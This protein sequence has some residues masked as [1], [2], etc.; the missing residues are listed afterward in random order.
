MIRGVS[1]LFLLAGCTPPL[2]A[3]QEVE[4]IGHFVFAELDGDPAALAEAAENLRTALAAEVDWEAGVTE[5]RYA[6]PL[7]EAPEVD[8]VPHPDVDPALQSPVA[9]A[10]RSE[11][12]VFDHATLQLESD[13][14]PF[15]PS[16]PDVY[17]RTLLE[18]GDCWP[19]DC[20]RLE[21]ENAIVKDN[22][23]YT[24]PYT[25]RKQ[26]VRVDLDGWT[27][28]LSRTWSEEIG[29]GELGRV[30][31]DQNYAVDTWMQDP[32]DAGRTLRL[33]YAWS[34]VTIEGVDMDTI[35]I[36][37]IIANGIDDTMQAQDAWLTAR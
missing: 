19:A 6:V 26:F 24:V 36:R 7:L 9:L 16:S 17:D 20:A 11:H 14:S 29:V 28:L 30:S 8:A 25:T 2:E 33:Q 5:R 1:G 4:A 18:G 35:D 12:D 37:G 34:S 15:E 3:P 23:L 27:A 22:F 13:Q 10:F 32:D 21:T 31:I